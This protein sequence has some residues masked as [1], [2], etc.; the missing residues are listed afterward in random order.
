RAWV[1]ELLGLHVCGDSL[2]LDPVIPGWWSGFR[3]T[4]RRGEALY[5]IQVD[6][7]ARVER[8][9]ASVE[10]DGQPLTDG[11]IP[12]ERELVKHRVVVRMGHGSAG[13]SAS[14]PST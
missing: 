11:V 5:E 9:V 12:L 1:E 3:L 13:P 10:M 14:S 2:R 4:Y 7:S 8:G 6:N